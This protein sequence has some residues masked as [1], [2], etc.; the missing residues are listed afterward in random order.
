MKRLTERFKNGQVG[1]AGC[2]T[3][4]KYDFK[5]CHNRFE[6]CPTIDEIYERLAQYEDIGLTPE[7]LLQIDKMYADRCR[8]ISELERR[9]KGK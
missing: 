9:I 4:C 5:Y 7:Q 3:K 1:I 2:G 8:E 6:D